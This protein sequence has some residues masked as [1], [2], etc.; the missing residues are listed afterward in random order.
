M[1]VAY[2]VII[3]WTIGNKLQWNF[4][5][6]SKFFTQENAIKSGLWNGDQFVQEGMNQNKCSCLH[7]GMEYQHT[8]HV[9]QRPVDHKK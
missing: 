3:N 8:Y 9:L 1:V 2:P 4:N 6:N 5:K 7:P